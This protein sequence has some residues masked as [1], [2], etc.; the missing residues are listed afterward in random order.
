MCSHRSFLNLI[1][2]HFVRKRA[3][4]G[5]RTPVTHAHD[6]APIPTFSGEIGS[7]YFP[8]LHGLHLWHLMRDWQI[9]TNRF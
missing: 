6:T 1:T 7:D 3:G 8:V 9:S 2:P 5:N 4:E